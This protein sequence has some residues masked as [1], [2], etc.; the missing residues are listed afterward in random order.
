MASG[1]VAAGAYSYSSTLVASTADTV[2]FADR[3]GY[4]QVSNTGTAGT[5][6][7]TNNGTAA[8][9]GG[10]STY[11]VNPGQA[12]VIANGL[13]LWNQVSK[14]IPAGSAQLPRGG[15]APTVSPSTTVLSTPANPGETLPYQSSG[16]GQVANP[17]VSLS[18][19]SSGTPTYTV[20]AAG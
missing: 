9:V 16:Q 11:A 6:Y 18:L 4:V 13:P 19:I 7:V 17:G 2:T 5:I 1:S 8:T 12:I 3:Y 15:G 10:A 14:V 20:S